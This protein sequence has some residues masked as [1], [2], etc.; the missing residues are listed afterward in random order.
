M[1]GGKGGQGVGTGKRGKTRLQRGQREVM[2]SKTLS[3]V[4]LHAQWKCVVSVCPVSLW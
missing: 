4:N 3:L 2:G 1:S